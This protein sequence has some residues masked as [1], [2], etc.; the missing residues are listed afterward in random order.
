MDDMTR[1]ELLA[2]IR[3]GVDNVVRVL[4]QADAPIS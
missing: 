1:A 2:G 3:Q 4:D